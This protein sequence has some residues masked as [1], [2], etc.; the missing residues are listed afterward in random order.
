ML[1]DAHAHV[2]T[3]I[4]GQVRAGPTRSMRYGRVAI[5]AEQV[6]AL[7]PVCDQTAHTV[8]MLLANLNWAGV[9]QAVLLQGPYYGECNAYVAKAVRKFSDRLVGAAYFD[10]WGG[11][12]SDSLERLFFT[13]AFRALKLEFSEPTGLSG[14]HPG[15]RLDDEHVSWLWDELERRQVTLVIDMGGVG[16]H[17]YQTRALRNIAEQHPNL[18]I[19]VPHLAQ[20][21]PQVEAD[22]HL[23]SQWYEQIKLGSLPNVWFDTA[24]L[25]AYVAHQEDFPFPSAEKYLRMAVDCIGADKIMWGTDVPGLLVFATYK[26]LAHLVVMHTQFLPQT[27][28]EKVLSGNARLVYGIG[29]AAGV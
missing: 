26:Q 3:R 27:D 19:V 1:I 16:S 4:Q 15:A 25:P 11:D 24:S 2:F 10:P 18:K 7:P 14:L 13:G 21:N 5:G 29:G 9:D 17:S 28:Q 23:K 8:E 6:Q 12:D 20:P 22:P